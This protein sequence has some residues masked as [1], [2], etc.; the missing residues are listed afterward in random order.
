V[1]HVIKHQPSGEQF[2]TDYG[3]K[4][5]LDVHVCLIGSRAVLGLHSDWGHGFE[6]QDAHVCPSGF[7]LTSEISKPT[8]GNPLN[9]FVNPLKTE[10]LLNNI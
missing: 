7:S 5:P 8:S 9:L 1:G 2:C 6:F 3:V 10:F 4:C